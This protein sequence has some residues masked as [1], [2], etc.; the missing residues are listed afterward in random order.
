MTSPPLAVRDISGDAAAYAADNP[1]VFETLP[2]CQQD[3]V[4]LGSGLVGVMI[5]QSAP[6]RLQFVMSRSDVYSRNR[7]VFQHRKPIGHC[8]L[9]FASAIRGGAA[10]LDIFR[11]EAVLELELADAPL[12]LKAI[13]HALDDTLIVEADRDLQRA[14]WSFFPVRDPQSSR[15]RDSRP[16]DNGPFEPAE[17][18]EFRSAN[19]VQIVMTRYRERG[20][21]AGELGVAAWRSH[22]GRRMHCAISYDRAMAGGARSELED[23]VDRTMTAA[24]AALLRHHLE[25][26]RAF[27]GRTF[28]RLPHKALEHFVWIQFHKMRALTR[29]GGAVIDL[30]GVWFDPSTPWPAMWHNLNSQLTYWL[31]P[32]GNRLDLMEPLAR[33][34]R[35]FEAEFARMGAHAGPD[36]YALD[37]ATSAEFVPHGPG[38]RPLTPLRAGMRIG[39]GTAHHGRRVHD[40][41]LGN[42]LWLVHN[43]WQC[44][45]FSDDRRMMSGPVLRF[46]RNGIRFYESF[47]VDGPDG[48]LHLPETFSPEYKSAPD[49]TYDVAILRWALT[50]YLEEAAESADTEHLRDLLRR[51]PDYACDSASGYMI[52]DGVPLADAH[53]HY[54]HLLMVHPFYDRNITQP[55]EPCRIRRSI[56]RWQGFSEAPD[57]PHQALVG[58][59]FTGAASLHSAIGDGDA[60]HACLTA[61][62]ATRAGGRLRFPNTQYYEHDGNDA[63]TVETPLTFAS[64]VCDMLLQ[65]W[66]GTASSRLCPPAGKT[67]ALTISWRMAALRSARSSPEAASSGSDSCRG[68]DGGYASSARFSANI[69]RSR[70]KSRW[71]RRFPAGS[72]AMTDPGQGADAGFHLPRKRVCEQAALGHRTGTSSGQQTSALFGPTRHDPRAIHP[73]H[74]NLRMQRVGEPPPEDM[75]HRTA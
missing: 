47:L 30:Q 2:A 63:T 75:T 57:R 15:T 17:I 38:R 51:L 11:A 24:P 42:F 26:W 56:E 35:E 50:A 52:G 28:I 66:G 44:A 9:R 27:M 69:P 40:A 62:L 45:R 16:A 55:G 67:P 5:W 8:T 61:F 60:A 70:W 74:F 22:R 34:M 73:A 48:H 18:D 39:D 37:T 13:C 1:I 19:G 68:G 32:V 29:P 54:S 31:F 43:L 65:S 53:R 46:L 33:S 64:A 58:Y 72:S 7:D 23:R 10:R 20:L 49:C 25:E 21:S 36:A 41:T 6:D 71:S 4:L 12:R 59:S 14:D 3:S